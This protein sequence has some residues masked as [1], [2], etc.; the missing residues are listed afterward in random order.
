MTSS[1]RFCLSRAWRRAD[2]GGCG[3]KGAWDFLQK[4][5]DPGKLLSLVDAALR[6]RQSVIARRQYGQQKLRVE[7]MGAANGRNSIASVYSSWQRRIL[8]SGFTAK[9][10]PGV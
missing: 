7:L 5:V 6:Q 2:G 4:P 8:R 1:C 10:E 3:E 9:R